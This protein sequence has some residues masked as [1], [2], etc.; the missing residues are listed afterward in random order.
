LVFFVA[1]LVHFS[2]LLRLKSGIPGPPYFISFP[3]K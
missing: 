2:L 1:I 3:W